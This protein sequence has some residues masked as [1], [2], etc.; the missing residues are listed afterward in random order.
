MKVFH[1]QKN[2]NKNKSLLLQHTDKVYKLQQMY[3][4]IFTFICK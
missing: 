2:S 1:F 4:S 3:F